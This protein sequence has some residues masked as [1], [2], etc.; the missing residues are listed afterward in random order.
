MVA[1]GDGVAFGSGLGVGVLFVS[2]VADVVGLGVLGV[3]GVTVGME[4]GDAVGETLG[5]VLGRLVPG[6]PPAE[7]HVTQRGG[8]GGS[9]NVQASQWSSR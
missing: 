3:V 4:V 9:S 6:V 5:H 7:P 1:V 8:H 2:G